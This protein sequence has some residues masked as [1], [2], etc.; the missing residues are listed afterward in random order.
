MSEPEPGRVY[1][2]K[3]VTGSSREATISEDVN[4]CGIAG[5]IVTKRGEKCKR[6]QRPA[7]QMNEHVCLTAVEKC[8]GLL[9]YVRMREGYRDSCCE[10]EPLRKT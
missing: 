4:Y 3:R 6:M 9:R 10:S 7:M 5:A 1:R 2:I 8:N